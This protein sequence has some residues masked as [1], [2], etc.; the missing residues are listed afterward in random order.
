MH[1]QDEGNTFYCD[2]SSSSASET[3]FFNKSGGEDVKQ[4]QIVLDRAYN[5]RPSLFKCSNIDLE[6]YSSH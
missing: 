6:V 2:I 3:D 4:L 1:I 5:C